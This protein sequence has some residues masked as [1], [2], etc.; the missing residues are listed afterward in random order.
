MSPEP[1]LIHWWG[2]E[3][4]PWAHGMSWEDFNRDYKEIV[5]LWTILMDKPFTYDCKITPLPT[6]APYTHECVFS[7]SE[8][9]I[10]LYVED[11]QWHVVLF[12]NDVYIEEKYINIECDDTEII[13]LLESYGL[14]LRGG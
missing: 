5:D 6:G 8:N 9:T 4:I 7:T 13:L 11:C 12:V 3:T 1:H 14:E 10:I 2:R